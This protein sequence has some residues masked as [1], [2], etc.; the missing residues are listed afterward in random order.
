MASIKII[1]NKNKTLSNGKHPIIMQVLKDRKK[2]VIYTGY[3][4]K[5]KEWNSRIN[6]P[7]K[8]H[9]NHAQLRLYLKKKLVDAETCLMELESEGKHFSID[10]LVFRI[11]G[12]K[13]TENV[14][15]F[16]EN[17]IKELERT[18]KIGNSKAYINTFN[19]FKKFR[20][21]K[22]LTF[23]E[24]DYKL[25]KKFDSYLLEQGLQ[26]NG[27]SFHMRT[28]RALYN[29]AV[30]DNLASK[31]NYPFSEYKIKKEKTVHRALSKEEVKRIKDLELNNKELELARDYFMF[32]FYT[33]GMSFIDIAY[34]QT[35]NIHHDRLS[36]KRAKTGQMFT[37]KLT[38]EAKD[39]IN[40][41]ADFSE[42][43]NYIFP[44]VQHEEKKFVQYKNAM[45]LTNKKLKLI[46]KMAECSIPVTTYVARHS[47]AT[48][49]KRGG[50]STSVISEGLGH[51]TERIT[52][53]YLDAF[54]N[55][56]L[57]D[58]NDFIT[59]LE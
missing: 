8:N 24:L 57:D 15:V 39:I 54:E 21:E 7:S 42:A 35:K 2:R 40:K 52:Q 20:N 14:F 37:I 41:Y 9:P 49:A 32:S 38:D 12:D 22:D 43:E 27:I 51:A 58:A 3:S 34:L 36:Y 55:N 6:E 10:E 4:A 45:R 33:R 23:N 30:K 46:G 47:W 31:D 19:T 56:V 29:R 53:V 13:K 44:I 50:I 18:G 1:I 17:V 48:I 28:L 5:N 59:R 11:K 25:V 16:W 26:V